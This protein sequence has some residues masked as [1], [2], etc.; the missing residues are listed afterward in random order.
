MPQVKSKMRNKEIGLTDGFIANNCGSSIFDINQNVI[1][2]VA[3]MTKRKI[4][5][6]YRQA[7]IA[8]DSVIF[9]LKILSLFT[10]TM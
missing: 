7:L 5:P 4:L 6:I 1:I 10:H 2:A 3:N 8:G 9:I